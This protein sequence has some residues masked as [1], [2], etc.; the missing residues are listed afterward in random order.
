M[1]LYALRSTLTASGLVRA[2]RAALGARFAIGEN[3][4]FARTGSDGAVSTSPDEWIQVHVAA[5]LA[6]DALMCVKSATLLTGAGGSRLQDL[7]G[8]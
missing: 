7:P 2:F 5:D 8:R 4:P 1:V 6:W 3:D